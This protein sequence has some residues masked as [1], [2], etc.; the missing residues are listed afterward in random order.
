MTEILLGGIGLAI[1]FFVVIYWRGSKMPAE[2]AA[3]HQELVDQLNEDELRVGYNETVTGIAYAS[4]FNF[5]AARI[6][7][8]AEIAVSLFIQLHRVLGA[9]IS[10]GDKVKRR[11]RL[12]KLGQASLRDASKGKK[13]PLLS[14]GE[15]K[16]EQDFDDLAN[17]QLLDEVNRLLRQ[18]G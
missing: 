7:A 5:S 15:L 3:K 18:A 6:I 2:I 4:D 1:A 17:R 9:R 8:E 13:R 11:N 16:V 12:L 14:G 10:T